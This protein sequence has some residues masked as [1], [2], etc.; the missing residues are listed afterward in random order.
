MW[1][2]GEEQRTFMNRTKYNSWKRR[3]GTDYDRDTDTAQGRYE[4]VTRIEIS[5]SLNE[6]QDLAGV[7]L[8]FREP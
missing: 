2:N 1:V 6:R 5:Q 7:I 8:R 4:V 3:L